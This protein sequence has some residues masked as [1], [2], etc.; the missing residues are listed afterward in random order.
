MIKENSP[1]YAEQAQPV[2]YKEARNPGKTEYSRQ[3]SDFST[4]AFFNA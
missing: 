4:N 3:E 2:S 1:Q